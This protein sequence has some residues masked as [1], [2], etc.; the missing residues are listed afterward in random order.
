MTIC[1]WYTDK[2]T[3]VDY[4]IGPQQTKVETYSWTV[5]ENLANSDVTITATLYYS[6]VPS[7]LGEFMELPTYAYE[8]RLVNST[9]MILPIRR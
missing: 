4:R 6:L 5:P 7:S 1:Q 2:N 8:P 3:E 9:S